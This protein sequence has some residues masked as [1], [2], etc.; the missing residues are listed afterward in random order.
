MHCSCTYQAYAHYH[1]PFLSPK[2]GILF[3]KIILS[4]NF[5]LAAPLE[6]VGHNLVYAL[7]VMDLRFEAK[8]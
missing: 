8:T 6:K 2:T 7:T 3:Y 4:H 5:S 1:L